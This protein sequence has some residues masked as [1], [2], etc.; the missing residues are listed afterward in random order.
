L[1]G[2]S[3]PTSLLAAQ[4]PSL[5][6]RIQ[7]T[8]LDADRSGREPCRH[9]RA[10]LWRIGRRAPDAMRLQAREGDNLALGATTL[11]FHHHPG[12]TPGVLSAEFTVYDNG[13]PYSS[14]RS[15]RHISPSIASLIT[16]QRQVG[17]GLQATGQQHERPFREA[18]KIATMRLKFGVH[19]GNPR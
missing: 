14:H 8:G 1:I 3:K 7:Q 13:M 17:L 10:I 4:L 16:R 15:S 5:N 2:A 11:K 19:L 6:A 18:R 12:H 9:F